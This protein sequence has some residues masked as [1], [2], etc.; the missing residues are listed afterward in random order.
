[1]NKKVSAS[2]VDVKVSSTVDLYSANDPLPAAD[3]MESD[4]DTVWALWEEVVANSN[5]EPEV[6][7]QS[8]ERAGLMDLPELSQPRSSKKD[9]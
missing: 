1:M 7:F 6:D 4:S 9:R 2:P 3:V 5:I 8:T